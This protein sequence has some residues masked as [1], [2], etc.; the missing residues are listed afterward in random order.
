MGEPHGGTSV[1]FVGISRQVETTHEF[2]SRDR[3]K[4]TKRMR[5][6]LCGN[7]S[8]RASNVLR[9]HMTVLQ[10]L[11]HQTICSKFDGSKETIVYGKNDIDFSARVL[12]GVMS[13][14]MI[15]SGGTCFFIRV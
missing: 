5:L 6:H 13:T 11:V 8:Y 15:R 12:L 4:E 9:N 7:A 2:K 14:S 10:Q 1:S 3:I